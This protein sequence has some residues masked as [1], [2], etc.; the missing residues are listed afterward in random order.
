MLI[1]LAGPA[2][3]VEGFRVADRDCSVAPVVGLLDWRR[4]STIVGLVIAIDVDAV[5]R[6][7][8]GSPEPEPRVRCRKTAHLD[9]QMRPACL[10][11]PIRH[12]N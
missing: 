11:P 6:L 1:V 4:P 7:A 12:K 8:H 2:G 10:P 3:G 5:Q 9:P